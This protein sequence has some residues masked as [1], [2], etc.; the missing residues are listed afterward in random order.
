MA[1]KVKKS[2]LSVSIKESM[3]K[4]GRMVG[5]TTIRRIPN[6]TNT[7]ER[8]ITCL[9]GSETTLYETSTD[10]TTSGSKF[11]AQKV[12]Y[13]RITNRDTAHALRLRITNSASDEMVMVL[14]PGESYQLFGHAKK[15]IMSGS[16]I[17]S[18]PFGSVTSFKAQPLTSKT[19]DVQLFVASI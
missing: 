1:T 12:K 16:A 4:D 19:I 14:E 13:G 9:G 18:Y 15:M 17:S 7:F 10:R 3:M 6:I 11:D 2:F 8:N 5:T